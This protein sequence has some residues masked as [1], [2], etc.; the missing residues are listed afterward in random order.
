MKPSI[1]LENIAKSYLVDQKPLVV[2]DHL[3][4]EIETDKISVILGKS[5]SGKT[6]LL[7]VLSNL[8]QV[9]SGHINYPSAFKTS[10]V[11]QEAR[12][13]P[14]LNTKENIGFGLEQD[15]D[16]LINDLAK[17]IGLSDFLNVYPNQLSGGMK[18]RVALARALAIKPDLIYMDE[19]FAALDY[20]TRDNMQDELIKL[21]QQTQ[22]GILFVTHNID[23]ALKIAH[24]ILVLDQGKIVYQIKLDD[25]LTN[26]DVLDNEKYIQ[27]KKKI[28]EMIKG[29]VKR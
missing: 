21:Y 6:T 22:T 29:E 5:G 24:N 1:K 17:M 27:I 14:W 7:R 12:L 4:L 13:M 16:S 20:F 19:P 2:L 3:N 9:D 25:D 8:E 18:A 23:E 10:F 28:L 26:R 11:F 15:N